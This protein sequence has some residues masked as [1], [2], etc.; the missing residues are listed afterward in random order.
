MA[1]GVGY[2][3]TVN[4]AAAAFTLNA[5]QNFRVAQ[6]TKGAGSIITNLFGF[7][8]DNLTNGGSNFGFYSTV[9]AAAGRY[10]FYAAGTAANFFQG[11]VATGASLSVGTSTQ[12]WV[13]TVYENGNAF[14]QY[15]NSVSGTA[16]TDGLLVGLTSSDAVVR[17]RGSGNVFLYTADTIRFTVTSTGN[18]HG[19]S[20]TTAMTDGFFYIPSAAG[21]PS[22]VPTAIT[23]RVPMYYD[24]T[25]N[26][27][28]IY[29][30]AWKKVLL[31]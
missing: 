5:V 23:G 2:I 8:C 11:T 27:F 6:G 17:N 4:T 28:Y 1:E 21:A 13:H 16:N 9:A 30:G 7:Y 26:N 14:T 20:G 15:I 12:N 19:T 29:N 25:N 3:A 31:A 22:G 18:L 24:T 10:N